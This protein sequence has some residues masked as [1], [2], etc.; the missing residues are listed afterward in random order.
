[1]L[2]K[3]EKEKTRKPTRSNTPKTEVKDSLKSFA[4]ITLQENREKDLENSRENED[5]EHL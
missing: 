4:R 3:L 5:K 2:R 1:M